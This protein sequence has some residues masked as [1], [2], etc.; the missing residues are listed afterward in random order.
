MDQLATRRRDPEL[1]ELRE[2]VALLGV[3]KFEQRARE[4]ATVLK[5][6]P[7]SFSRWVSTAAEHR[8]SERGFR[9]TTERAR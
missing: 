6:N 8:S 7:G 4:M 2:L 9:E 3:E 5:K 1:R